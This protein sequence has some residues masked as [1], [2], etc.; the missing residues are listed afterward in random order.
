MRKLILIAHTSLDGFVAGLHGEL[1]GF[2]A[3]EENLKFVCLLTESSDSALFG[4]VSY[5]LLNNYWP[6]AKDRPGATQGEIAYSNWYNSAQKIVLSRSIREMNLNKTIFISENIADEVT[7]IKKGAGKN[8]LIFGSPA[9]SQLLMKHS[10]IDE[11]WIFVNPIIF[12]KGIPLFAETHHKIKLKLDATK[13]FFNDEF[14]LHYIVD[15][16]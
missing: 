7:R 8:I 12:G 9:V 4:R 2:D 13:Q 1:D 10:L 6:T 11:Y 14:A 3:S 5:Q 15:R 16:S